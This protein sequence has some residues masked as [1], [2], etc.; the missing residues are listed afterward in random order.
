MKIG[1]FTD[2]LRDLSFEAALDWAASAGVEAVEIGTGNFSQA[3]HC[4]VDALIEDSG[5]RKRF[6]EALSKRGGPGA[7]RGGP[8]SQYRGP[9]CR[10]LETRG[11]F[12]AET[13]RANGDSKTKRD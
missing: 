4:D 13:L 2:S 1:L 3:P 11:A 5:A 9:D 8:M 10:W 6:M 12:D 7:S